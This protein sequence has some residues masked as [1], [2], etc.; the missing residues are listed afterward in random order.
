MLQT[1]A[2]LKRHSITGHGATAKRGS[3]N[4]PKRWKRRRPRNVWRI[5]HAPLFVRHASPFGTLV[6]GATIGATGHAK[7]I[8]G[9]VRGNRQRARCESVRRIGWAS[10]FVVGLGAYVLRRR[11]ESLDR[12]PAGWLFLREAARRRRNRTRSGD[13]RCSA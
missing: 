8:S 10:W 7:R 13:L 9:E 12:R 4:T 3:A 5:D 6:Y 11:Q 1:L 2:P